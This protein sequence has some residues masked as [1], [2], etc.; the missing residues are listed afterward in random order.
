[1]TERKCGTCASF[2]CNFCFDKNI[3]VLP[4]FSCSKW[5]QADIEPFDFSKVVSL[6]EHHAPSPVSYSYL[7]RNTGYSGTKY[8]M[9]KHLEMYP[10]IEYLRL[11]NRCTWRMRV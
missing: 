1:M 10:N 11:T 6:I 7:V 4:D 2:G 8:M 3:H 5:T 9:K